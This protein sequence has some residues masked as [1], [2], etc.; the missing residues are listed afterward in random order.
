[1]SHT[2]HAGK[3]T[4]FIGNSD[5]SG[6]ITIHHKGKEFDVPGWTLLHFVANW[7]REERKSALDSTP[8]EDILGVRMPTK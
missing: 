2:Y 4:W 1:M 5:L 8:P 6:D 3:D 7:V